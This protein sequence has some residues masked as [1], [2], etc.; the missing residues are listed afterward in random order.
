MGLQQDIA[1][2]EKELEAKLQNISTEVL[3]AQKNGENNSEASSTNPASP[4]D[5]SSES[6]TSTPVSTSTPTVT[7]TTNSSSP[8]AGKPLTRYQQRMKE[9]ISQ[10]GGPAIPGESVAER[11]DR[12]EMERS[13]LAAENGAKDFYAIAKEERNKPHSWNTTRTVN[14]IIVPGKYPANT[15]LGSGEVMP[16]TPRLDAFKE[17]QKTPVGAEDYNNW[18]RDFQQKKAPDLNTDSFKM[19][20]AGELPSFNLNAPKSVGASAPIP[21]GNAVASNGNAGTDLLREM[22]TKLSYISN[23]GDRANSKITT[24]IG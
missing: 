6:A 21:T 12:L 1:K 10:A 24:L 20:T 9:K 16:S 19:K 8:E 22:A 11:A 7:P 14:G 4:T 5:S 2:R 18:R 23:Q 13:S 15:P 17:S 3:K